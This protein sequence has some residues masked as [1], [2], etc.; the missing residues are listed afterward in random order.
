MTLWQQILT[1][2]LCVAATVATRF[3]PF[4]LFSD[5]RKTPRF[6][7]YL[8]RALPPALFGMLVVYALK[9]VSWLGGFGG[10]PELIGMAVTVGV[11]LLWRQMIASIAA[12]TV[13]YMLLV[14]FVF[15]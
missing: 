3:L 2:A 4:V 8:G 12:G 7:T 11:H 10:L 5:H 9:D 14:Q 6:V 15:I 13:V 1:I